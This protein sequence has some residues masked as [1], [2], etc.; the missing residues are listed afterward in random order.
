MCVSLPG[1]VATVNFRSPVAIGVRGTMGC[2]AAGQA[3]FKGSHEED[4]SYCCSSVAVSRR[5]DVGRRLAAMAWA[6]S[7]RNMDGERCTE[8]FPSRRAEDPL[9]Q[10][11]DQD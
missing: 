11:S 9:A 2:T 6:D 7:E 4:I 3:K 8:G 1:S 5:T 10:R